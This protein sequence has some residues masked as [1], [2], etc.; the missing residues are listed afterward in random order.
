MTSRIATLIA[1]AATLVSGGAA[2]A[3]GPREWQLGLPEPVTPTA[4]KIASFHDGLLVVITV[5]SVFVLLLLLYTCVRF[6]ES[7]N[8]N[9]STTTHNTLIEFVW[10][11]VPIV[12]LVGIAVPSFRLLYFADRTV[13]ADMTLKIIGNQWYWSYEYPDHGNF[14]FDANLV[15]DAEIK[16]GQLRLLETDNPVVLP[17]GKKVRL[18][19]TSQDVIHAWAITAF[20]VRLDNVPGRT[21]ETWVQIDKPGT[22]YG[23]CSELCGTGHSYMP[24]MVKAVSPAE[25]AAWVEKAKKEFARVD[26]APAAEPAKPVKLAERTASN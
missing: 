23:Y 22:Y 5:I 16:P 17:V 6:R 14:T 19:L 20:G 15:P 3:A 18:L 1:G 10:T 26:E 12:I 11:V 7:K 9:P 8:P 21:N 24:I 13:N 25:F 2:F 4:E